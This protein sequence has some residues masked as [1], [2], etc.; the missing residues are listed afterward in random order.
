MEKDYHELLK[1]LRVLNEQ[2]HMTIEG[3]K[4][5]NNQIREKI[6]EIRKLT[7]VCNPEL[8]ELE[9]YYRYRD[10][11]IR[12]YKVVMSL[13]LRLANA[14]E[15]LYTMKEVSVTD[16][17]DVSNTKEQLYGKVLFITDIN[18]MG[19]FEHSLYFN[20]EFVE[21]AKNYISKG[22]SMIM[23]T[24]NIFENHVK[25][26]KNE[27]QCDT[28]FDIYNSGTTGNI[29]C[30]L[31]GPSIQE[32]IKKFTDYVEINGPDF[33]GIDE[34]SLFELINNSNKNQ[35]TL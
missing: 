19:Q 8:D 2:Y 25:P 6:N 16:F 33:S 12:D 26:H 4:A 17:F 9:T 7:T 11:Y 15:E 29:T 31:N 18:L 23:I 34:D 21:K 1:E 24:K 10:Y 22:H 14:E 20:K 35:K 5:I 30:Y 27:I 32:A 13:L 28:V 3:R